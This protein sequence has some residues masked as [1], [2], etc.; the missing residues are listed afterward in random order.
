MLRPRPPLNIWNVNRRRA[1]SWMP[2]EIEG[3][4]S[5]K[6]LT[7]RGDVRAHIEY[8]LIQGRQFRRMPMVNGCTFWITSSHLD[9]DTCCFMKMDG[10]SADFIPF[11]QRHRSCNHLLLLFLPRFSPPRPNGKKMGKLRIIRGEMKMFINSEARASSYEIIFYIR[12]LK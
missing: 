1:A 2:S 12:I 10:L 5:L 8:L 3:N 11:S 6:R 7:P 4:D 9:G